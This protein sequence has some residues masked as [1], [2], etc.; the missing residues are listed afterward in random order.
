MRWSGYLSCG[1]CAVGV[2]ANRD[3][4]QGSKPGGTLAWY[5]VETIGGVEDR[6]VRRTDELLLARVVIDGNTGMGAGA[7]AGHEVTVSE[8][9]EQA[10]LTIGRVS[11]GDG[12]IVRHVGMAD[13]CAGMGWRCR[14]GGRLRRL[15]RR[16]LRW[17]LG[18]LSSRR[19]LRIFG[20]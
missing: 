2:D 16:L 1:D 14:C 20:R 12:A 13:D 3:S 8:T 9:D 19:W 5:L 4:W 10:T 6:V 18:R 7:L 17:L 11:E 15:W